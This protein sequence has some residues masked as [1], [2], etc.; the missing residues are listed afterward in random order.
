MSEEFT[1]EDVEAATREWVEACEACRR[2]RGE[3]IPTFWAE[4]GESPPPEPR[5]VTKEARAEAQ[6]LE[7]KRQKAYERWARVCRGLQGRS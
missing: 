6:R 1:I 2:W 7:L 3:Y 5:V 4:S